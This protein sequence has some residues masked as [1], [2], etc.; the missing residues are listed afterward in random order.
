MDSDG[1]FKSLYWTVPSPLFVQYHQLRLQRLQELVAR[2]GRHPAP[3]FLPRSLA[4]THPDHKLIRESHT[5]T[6]RVLDQR[7]EQRLLGR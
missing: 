2:R 6:P 4:H 7:Q 3:S 1:F 5:V